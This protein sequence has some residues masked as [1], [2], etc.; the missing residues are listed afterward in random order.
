MFSSSIDSFKTPYR[1]AFMK[2][3]LNWVRTN[4]NAGMKL[5]YI[6]F[7]GHHPSKT[8]EVVKGCFSQ[9]WASEFVHENVLYRTAEHWMMAQ[10]AKLFKDEEIYQETL[11]CMS[12]GKAKQLGRQVKNFDLEEWES[13][14][15]SIVKAG[16]R[17][18]F[19]QNDPLRRF[20]LSTGKRVLVEASPHDTI[21]GVGM[22]EGDQGI[23]NPN[24]WKGQNLLGFAIMEVRDELQKTV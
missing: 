4:F 22:K 8:G 23:E 20:L 5:K 13:Q 6:F 7:W 19:D 10:K 9:W 14:R 21:W 17:M 16:N 11:A 2:Y 15:Y 12:P 1:F 18:K 3:N 24:N